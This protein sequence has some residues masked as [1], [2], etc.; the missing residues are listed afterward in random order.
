V[1]EQPKVGD[2]EA[3]WRRYAGELRQE[4]GEVKGR[5]TTAAVTQLTARALVAESQFEVTMRRWVRSE[6]TLN[7]LERDLAAGDVERAVSRLAGRRRRI[8]R[9]A[10]HGR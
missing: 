8:E 2:G 7:N 3:A 4:L 1:I 10:S 6:H 5:L 9:K